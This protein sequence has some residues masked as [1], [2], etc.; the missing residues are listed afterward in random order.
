MNLFRCAQLTTYGTRE[1][2]GR[3]PHLM[4]TE[5]ATQVD[6]VLGGV[7]NPAAFANGR[8]AL[9]LV[10]AVRE[11]PASGNFSL[12]VSR[13]LDD[14]YTPGVFKVSRLIKCLMT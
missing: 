2:S 13:S 11:P 1:R 14:E 12:T 9:E 8:L 10:T 4:H 3:L 6:V 7:P 5:N